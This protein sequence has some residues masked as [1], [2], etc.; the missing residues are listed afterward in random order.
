MNEDVEKRQQILGLAAHLAGLDYYQVLKVD[1][2][3]QLPEIKKAF[4]RESQAWH[5]DRFYGSSDEQLKYAVMSVYKRIA[6]AYGV[7]RDPDLRP[8]YDAQLATA[9]AGVR[10]DRREAEQAASPQGAEPKSKNPQAQRYV[11]MAMSCFRKQDY[12]G[13]E[14][15]FNFAL[16]YEPGN[17]SV[18]KKLKE[19]QELKAK[20][21]NT[22]DPY[23]IM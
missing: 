13:A 3:A 8:R 22:K 9:G 16:K 7:L 6:E 17:E 4:F 12:A 11:T 2:K 15:N 5:P 14:M 21:D 23:K 20:K 10:L 18:A 19:A 1:R